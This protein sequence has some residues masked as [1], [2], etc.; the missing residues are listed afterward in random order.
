MKHPSPRLIFAAMTLT[1][2][3][4]TAAAASAAGSETTQAKSHVICLINQD[5]TAGGAQQG[6]CLV[7]D[8]P[9]LP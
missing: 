2:L 9:T 8:D 7:W 1:L 3:G 6:L 4:G 5:P